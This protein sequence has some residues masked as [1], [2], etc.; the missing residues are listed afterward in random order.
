MDLKLEP[1][2]KKRN[3]FFI[4]A[5]ANNGIRQSN[6]L[7]FEKYK[8]WTGLLIEAIPS[9]ANECRQN[10]KK[11][12]VENCALVANEY[13]NEEIEIDYCNLMSTIKGGSL[14]EEWEKDHI[15]NG[16]QYLKED[17]QTYTI[18]VKA[19]TLTE[20]LDK[21][22]IGHIDLFSLDVEGYESE[23]LKG[24]DLER[25][26]PDHMLIE[27]RSGEDLG[28]ILNPYY[29]PIA[30]LNITDSYSDVLYRSNKL[31]L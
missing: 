9:L 25:Y 22:N 29:K 3:G 4:E 1:Y 28:P 12:I 17:D 2:I 18:S 26:L 8:G 24:L 21:H 15:Q 23:V 14:G 13:P 5:G 27:V 11:C 30:A 6:T 16:T 7:Y 20:I 10:R 19:Q 31:S